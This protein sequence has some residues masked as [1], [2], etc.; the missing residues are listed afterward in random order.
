MARI[1]TVKPEFWASE[2]IMSCSRDARLLFIGLFNFVDDAGRCPYAPKTIKA[3]VLPGDDDVSLESWLDELSSNGLIRIYEVDK[4]K[5]LQ[6]TGWHH[7]KIDRPRASRYPGPLPDD[8]TNGSRALAT[9]LT[10][11]D[12]IKDPMGAS[13]VS[14]ALASNWIPK[15]RTIDEAKSQ[16]GLTEADITAMRE[17]FCPYYRA[18]GEKR[19]DWDEQFL[20]WCP[21]EAKKLGRTPPSTNSETLS[22]IFVTADT[23]QWQ[24]WKDYLRSQGKSGCPETES[25]FSGTLQRGWYFETEWPPNIE[26]CDHKP[27]K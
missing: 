20:A 14:R 24:A 6:I 18:K 4:R 10:L 13:G 21:D 27:R 22:K 25:I 9:D 19:F 1:R 12:R 16:F 26:N 15:K 7:Q 23:P 2:Q 3:Q 11:P 8:S 17:R 5:Y